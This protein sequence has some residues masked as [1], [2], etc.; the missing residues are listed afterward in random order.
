MV[1][2]LVGGG[3]DARAMAMGFMYACITVSSEHVIQQ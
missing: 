2:P 1:G 3:P